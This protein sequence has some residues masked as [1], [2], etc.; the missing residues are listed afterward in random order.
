VRAAWKVTQVCLAK[1]TE[2]DGSDYFASD[3]C[4]VIRVEAS[5]RPSPPSELEV[6]D[7]LRLEGEEGQ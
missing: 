2:R 1:S 5:G 6:G 4:M 3:T 7:V